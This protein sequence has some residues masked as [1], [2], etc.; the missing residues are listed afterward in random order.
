MGFVDVTGL[1]QSEEA[2]RFCAEKG[3]GRVQRGDVCSLPF[4]IIRSIGTGDGRPGAVFG[5]YRGNGGGPARCQASGIRIID[6]AH[7]ST[8][9]GTAG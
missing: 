7:V 5:R 3:L 4:R 6:C 8:T 1:D 9:L 2:I